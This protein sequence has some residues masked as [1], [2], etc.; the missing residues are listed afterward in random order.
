MSTEKQENKIKIWGAYAGSVISIITLLAISWTYQPFA[1][2]AESK[3]NTAAI[4]EVADD[5][6]DLKEKY[7]KDSKNEKIRY[8]ILN[9]QMIS[10]PLRVKSDLN[11]TEADLLET[12]D[13]DIQH[14]QDQ[15]TE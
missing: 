8:E 14:L 7:K 3:A 5:V 10:L 6:G 11:T 15:L 9:V 4:E 12:F 13:K 1:L 2:A